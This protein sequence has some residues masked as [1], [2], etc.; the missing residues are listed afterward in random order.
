MPRMYDALWATAAIYEN[1]KE[2]AMA[3]DTW[4]EIVEVL[5]S[6]WKIEYG[7]EIDFPKR[8]EMRLRNRVKAK[9]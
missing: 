8:E 1:T 5:K 2:Y 7:E 3:A 4:H 6:E 9:K